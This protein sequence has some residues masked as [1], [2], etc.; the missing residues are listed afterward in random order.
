MGREQIPNAM[1]EGQPINNRREEFIGDAKWLMR[2][3]SQWNPIHDLQRNQWEIEKR[4][5]E[6]G[7]RESNT[8]PTERWRVEGKGKSTAIDD[9]HYIPIQLNGIQFG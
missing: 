4:H 7:T 1:S 3:S 9:I 6:R 2:R 5:F 8:P